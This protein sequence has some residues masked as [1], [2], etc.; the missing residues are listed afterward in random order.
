[1]RYLGYD[2]QGDG[3]FALTLNHPED[4]VSLS[5]RRVKISNINKCLN[6]RNLYSNRNTYNG[7]DIVTLT[8]LRRIH[9]A[10]DNYQQNSNSLL[11]DLFENNKLEYVNVW[12]YGSDSNIVNSFVIQNNI[13]NLRFMRVYYDEGVHDIKLNVN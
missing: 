1:M 5:T 12:N 7:D 13:E 9:S 8:N 11:Q 3:N 6:L 2:Y 10:Y 4:L